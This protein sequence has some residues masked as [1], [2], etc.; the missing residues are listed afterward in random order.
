MIVD[1]DYALM[2][3][4]MMRMHN[5]DDDDNNDNDSSKK[6]HSSMSKISTD[7]VRSWLD[8]YN[9]KNT[10]ECNRRRKKDK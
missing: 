7:F 9:A 4:S 2:T 1:D 6:V 10:I 3:T 5:C 8:I